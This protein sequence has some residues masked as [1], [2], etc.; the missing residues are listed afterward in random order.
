VLMV[1]KLEFKSRDDDDDGDDDDVSGG[2]Q[3]FE[4]K[5]SA[6]CISCADTSG[7]FT[8]KGVT[9][10]YDAGTE[11]KDGLSGSTL[12][13]KTVEVKSVGVLTATGTSYRATRI[14]LDD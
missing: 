11:F 1:T 14:E 9:V 5:G 7:T 4:F 2:S 13:G 8:V 12:D 10:R 3:E 6:A